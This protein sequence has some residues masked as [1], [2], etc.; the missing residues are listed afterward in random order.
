MAEMV[1]A[2]ISHSTRDASLAC[3]LA[4]DL[5]ASGV[6]VWMAPKSIP[7]GSQWPEQL[8]RG[9]GTSTHFV[10]L[11]TPAA[12]ESGWVRQEMDTAMILEKRGRLTILILEVEKTPIPAFW[13]PYQ[14]IPFPDY[15]TGFANLLEAIGQ[16]PPPPPAPNPF[17]PL[18]GRIDDPALF[19]DRERELSYIFN[20]LRKGSSL[21]IIGETAVGK[22]SLLKMVCHYGPQRLGSGW[23]F[24]YL[25]LQLVYD[26]DD[27]YGAICNEIGVPTCKGYALAR[28]L[29]G[30]RIVLCLDEVEKMT[31]KGF[32]R[33]VRSQLRGLAEGTDAPL[34]LLIA[35]RTPLDRLFP[36][37][38]GM[39][40]P[41]AG[42]CQQLDFKPFDRATAKAFIQAHLQDTGVDFP[43]GEVE[44]ILAES[45]GHPQK[46]MR[47]CSALYDRLT[48][49]AL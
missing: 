16:T 1:K 11:L 34:R 43:E 2:F 49:G 6:K 28:A 38:K 23:Q 40:S 25:D 26:E 41:L 30:R 15:A 8:S 5:K 29:M 47:L 13:E 42:L 32:T 24:V 22:S 20:E 19:F 7:P 10:L 48:G 14:R 17:Y 46:L 44:R 12:L 31:W 33:N 18:G 45:G 27:L 21:A 36:D 39:T 9:L 4:D 3:R 37:S 35:A